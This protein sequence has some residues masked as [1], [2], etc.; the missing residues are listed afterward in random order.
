MGH[1]T[2]EIKTR[3]TRCLGI[4]SGKKMG[5]S[6][7]TLRA[8]GLHALRVTVDMQEAREQQGAL[9]DM[10]ETVRLLVH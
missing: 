6:F 1:D 9:D 7:L 5:A 4:I 3:S 2:V 10:T 8:Q